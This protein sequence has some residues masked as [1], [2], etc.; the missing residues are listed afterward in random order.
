MAPVL[1]SLQ[2]IR[3]LQDNYGSIEPW[4]LDDMSIVE[5]QE[6]NINNLV[7]QTNVNDELSKT[8]KSLGKRSIL[9]EEELEWYNEDSVDEFATQIVKRGTMTQ[10]SLV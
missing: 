4:H 10:I 9:D 6:R 2:Q 1:G 7:V 3:P 5:R 8:T